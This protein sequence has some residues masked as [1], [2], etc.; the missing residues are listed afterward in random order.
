MNLKDLI[1]LKFPFDL[2]MIFR[3]Q[4]TILLDAKLFRIAYN[5]QILVLNEIA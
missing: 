5:Q 1:H 3:D 2:I 4:K